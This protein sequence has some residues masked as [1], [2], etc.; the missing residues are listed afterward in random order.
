MTQFIQ[1]LYEYLFAMIGIDFTNYS[2]SLPQQFVNL[3][4]YVDKFF[5][6]VVI[7]FFV[8]MIYNFLIFLFSLGGIR[9]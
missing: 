3:Y 7:F 8:Y 1:L 2:G 5:H 6:L 9:K 4:Q